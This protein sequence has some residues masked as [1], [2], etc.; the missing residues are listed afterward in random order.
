M[1][2]QTRDPVVVLVD[3]A[4]DKK[5][6]QG[7]QAQHGQQKVVKRLNSTSSGGAQGEGE[8]PAL[9][10]KRQCVVAGCR[11]DARP[12]SVYCSDTC[13]VAHARESLLAMSKLESA[14][15]AAA[16]AAVDKP[17]ISPSTPTPPGGSKWKES[18]EFGQLM[19]QPTPLTTKSKLLKKPANLADDAPVPVMERRTGKILT[20]SNAPRVA[21]L[22]QWLKDHATFEVIKPTSLP[23]KNRNPPAPVVR[24]TSV[25]Q[26]S[27]PSSS[28]P[29]PASSKNNATTPTNTATTP[30]SN[31]PTKKLERPKIVRKR[32]LET[33]KDEE[34]AKKAHPDPESTRAAAKTSLKDALWNR[35]KEE[36]DLAGKID[37]SGAEAVA[38]EVEAALYR[39]FNK[40]VGVKYKAKYRSLIFNIKD[41]KNLGLFRQIVEKQ[42]TPGKLFLFPGG[43]RY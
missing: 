14:S 36:P 18:V 12:N 34:S 11:N 19:S 26:P 42:I 7:Q 20:G 4:K 5:A 38:N 6:L 13:I 1:A 16:A 29:S 3:V 10:A 25:S 43:G 39:H 41:P 17:A 31:T 15:A 27:T 37:E 35:C 8:N 32:S 23:N 33:A 2:A 40:D 22:E 30:T 21:N 24:S 28:A 9:V